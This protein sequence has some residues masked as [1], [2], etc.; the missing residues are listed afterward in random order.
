MKMANGHG[1]AYLGESE[2]FPMFADNYGAEF[3]EKFHQTTSGDVISREQMLDILTGI[4]FRATLLVAEE[5]VTRIDRNYA[6][7]RLWACHFMVSKFIKIELSRGEARLTAPGGKSNT[8]SDPAVVA[9][10]ERLHARAP[11][12]MSYAQCLEGFSEDEH[13]MVKNMLQS[14]VGGGL[15]SISLEPMPAAKAS[16]Q[17]CASH[18]ARVDAAAGRRLTAT[19]QHY[20]V[21]LDAVARFLLPHLDGTADH[22]QLE[23]LLLAA[24]DAGQVKIEAADGSRPPPEELT[25]VVSSLVSK[26]LNEIA[27]LGILEA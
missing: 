11:A 10:I 20:S 6:S 5:R 4:T 13:S 2:I 17:P 18:L 24:V 14:M 15:V 19:R 16:Q 25:E 27:A 9:L 12:S 21:E 8:Y 7:D 26:G 23:K 3:A 1:L 22:A